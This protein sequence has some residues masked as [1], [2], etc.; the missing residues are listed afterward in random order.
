MGPSCGDRRVRVWVLM[1]ERD[2]RLEKR[3]PRT[4]GRFWESL[5]RP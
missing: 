5:W 2:W 3:L 4:V 1:R